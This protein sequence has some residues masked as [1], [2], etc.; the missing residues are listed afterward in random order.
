M[1]KFEKFIGIDVFSEKTNKKQQQIK[2]IS[3][4]F[5]VADSYMLGRGT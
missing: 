5:R 1:E 2:D 4:I 3:Y